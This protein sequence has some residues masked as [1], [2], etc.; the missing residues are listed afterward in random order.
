MVL[1][2]QL[3]PTAVFPTCELHAST[4]SSQGSEESSASIGSTR[5]G[6]GAFDHL[7]GRGLTRTWR[8]LS[9]HSL[10]VMDGG[11]SMATAAATR[12]R[13]RAF[14]VLPLGQPGPRSLAR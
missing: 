10:T 5:Y 13:V 14:T 11:G 6:V 3:R 7:P 8:Y 1:P 9:A 4:T 2:I 12:Q